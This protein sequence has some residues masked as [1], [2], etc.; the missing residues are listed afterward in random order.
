MKTNSTRG[1]NWLLVYPD[2]FPP[3]PIITYGDGSDRSLLFLMGLFPSM[4]LIAN[5]T[6]PVLL[7]V[8]LAG[9]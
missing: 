4:G 1:G 7:D 3:A 8:Y 5:A 9:G 6:K 2:I